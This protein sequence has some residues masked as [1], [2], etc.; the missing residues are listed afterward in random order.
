MGNNT[1]QQQVC[2]QL[3]VVKEKELARQLMYVACGEVA[4]WRSSMRR[5]QVA[6]VLRLQHIRP[7]TSSSPPADLKNDA[8][9]PLTAFIRSGGRRRFRSKPLASPL[10]MQS[11]LTRESLRRR[12]CA[13][14]CCCCCCCCELTVTV[15]ITASPRTVRRPLLTD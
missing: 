1:R 8:R 2:L 5:A 3:L 6:K 10:G 9:R 14:D 4:R 7:P 15:S 12:T 13:V 11:D